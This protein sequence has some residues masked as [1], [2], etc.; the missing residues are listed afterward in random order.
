MTAQTISAPTMDLDFSDVYIKGGN[1]YEVSELTAGYVLEWSAV[2]T[3]NEASIEDVIFRGGN[4]YL[5]TAA[6]TV[7]NV[8][9]MAVEFVLT[10]M[11]VDGQEFTFRIAD[12]NL[13]ELRVNRSRQPYGK[14]PK[15][16]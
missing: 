3:I 14:G 5:I 8:E 11:A 13:Y 1:Q 6:G 7:Y 9:E 12:E 10:V 15:N 16:R 2:D 4:Y